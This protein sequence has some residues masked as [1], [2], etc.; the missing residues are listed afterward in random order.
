M[1]IAFDMFLLLSPQGDYFFFF[2]D[3]ELMF[4]YLHM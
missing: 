3:L 1:T 4:L 2:V